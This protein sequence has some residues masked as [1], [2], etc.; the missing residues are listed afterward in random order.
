MS[1][2]AT[3]GGGEVARGAPEKTPKI[4]DRTKSERRLAWYL[5]APAVA[6]MLLVTAYPII[7]AT[8]LSVQDVDLR[9]PDEGGFAGLENYVTVLSSELWWQSVFNTVFITV[10]HVGIELVLGMVIALVM[11][12]ALFARGSSA[13]PF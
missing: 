12:R 13:P 9:F 10:V 2:A 11:Y 1:G 8:I 7:Y 5:C 4:S 3:T 6:A